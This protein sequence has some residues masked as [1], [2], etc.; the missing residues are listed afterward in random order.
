[1]K[2]IIEKCYRLR[3]NITRLK[4]LPKN[5][6]NLYLKLIIYRCYNNKK[7]TLP[8]N[9]KINEL[10]IETINDNKP[11]IP[12]SFIYDKITFNDIKYEI[13]LPENNNNK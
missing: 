12:D 13:I 3:I 6:N 9:W 4:Y 1:L 7:Y 2:L 8:I 5:I 11:I 10:Y